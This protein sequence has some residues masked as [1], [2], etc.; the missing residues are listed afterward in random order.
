MNSPTYPMP[1]SIGVAP[2]ASRID[3]GRV[4]IW[5]ASALNQR[6]EILADW[7]ERRWC[8]RSALDISLRPVGT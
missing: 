6:E 7:S 1:L 4:P 2:K 3:L 8:A 5:F